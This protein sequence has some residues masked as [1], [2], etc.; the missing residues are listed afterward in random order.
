MIKVDD[1]HFEFDRDP[2]VVTADEEF[3]HNVFLINYWDF[4]FDID[5]GYSELK[6]PVEVCCH[7][8]FLIE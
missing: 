5:L 1:D 8:V 6:T 4:H 7:F 2:V 3:K